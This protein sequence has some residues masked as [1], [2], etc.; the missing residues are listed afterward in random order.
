MIDV[1]K[2]IAQ[3][4]DIGKT[5]RERDFFKGLVG[6]VGVLC[7]RVTE[8]ESV[9]AVLINR[10]LDLESRCVGTGPATVTK[11]PTKKKVT[12]KPKGG[13]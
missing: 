11:P 3:A 9:V 10:V 7:N 6:E 5:P 2:L 13:E 4:N 8:T 1:D 12:K